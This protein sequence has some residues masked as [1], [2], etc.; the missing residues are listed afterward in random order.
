MLTNVCFNVLSENLYSESIVETCFGSKVHLHLRNL[1]TL[2]AP[3]TKLSSEIQTAKI[4]IRIVRQKVKLVT[5]SL[6]M[7]MTRDS[8]HYDEDREA[9]D[10]EGSEV[11]GG[12]EAGL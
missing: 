4:D 9:G 11:A 6:Q 5:S 10:R 3:T 8:Q 1:K 2:L 7:T 12:E